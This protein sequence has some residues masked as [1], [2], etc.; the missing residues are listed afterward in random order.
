MKRKDKEALALKARIAER[1][2]ITRAGQGLSQ[3]QVA[4][5]TMIS[6]S[7]VS[8]HER[9]FVCPDVDSLCRYADVYGATLDYLTGRSDAAPEPEEPETES[10]K[11]P[12]EEA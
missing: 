7:R 10:E 2:S 5:K 9:G 6:P 12:W 8:M 11:D 3:M 4:S 1:L